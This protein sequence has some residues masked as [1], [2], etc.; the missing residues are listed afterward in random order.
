[1]GRMYE[2][3][4]VA[5]LAALM[6]VGTTGLIGY[7]Q[8]LSALSISQTI[9]PQRIFLKGSGV[10]P[11]TAKVTL[12]LEAPQRPQRLMTD[13][14][15]V[16]DRSASFEM[17]QAVGAAQRIIDLLGPN[18]RVGLVSFATE[19]TLDARL[20][21]VASAQVVRDALSKLVSEGKTALG[22]GI[23]VATDELITSGRREA[24]LI[25]ILLTDGRTNSGRDPLEEARKANERNV[26]IYAVGIGR[27]VNRDALAQI[28][29]KTGGQFFSAYNDAI[30]DQ[31]LRVTVPANEPAA[32]NIEIVE[33]LSQ[34][35]YYEEALEN[36]PSSV[37]RNSD[38]TTTLTWK[39][40]SLRVG[41]LWTIRYTVSGSEE[42]FIPLHRSPSFVRFTDFRDREIQS[43]LSLGLV[44]EVRPRPPV[45]TPAFSVTPDNPTTY[46]E[47]QFT[48]K[49]KVEKGKIVRW[50]WSLGDGATSVEQNPVHRYAA[51]GSYAIMLTV[52]SDEGV[53]ASSSSTITVFT[54][55]VAVRRTIDT[56]IPVDQTIPGQTF[57]V[58]LQI[59]VNKRLN[60]L[61]V[62]EN[63]PSGWTVSVIE[64]STAELRLEDTQWLFSEVLEQGTVKTILYEVTVP[65]QFQEDAVY[66][67]DG[68]A[69]SASPQLNLPVTGDSEIEVL[70]GFSIP[71]VVAHWD[72]S[73]QAL[74]LKGH[75]K[76]KIDLNQILRAI[77]WWR[78]GMEVPSTEDATGK[79]K[80]IDFKTMQELVAYWLTD[81][82]VF[83]PLPKE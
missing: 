29:E 24:A 43:D 31:I 58:T 68:T 22:E 17:G 47:V 36:A 82:S 80:K 59:Q 2:R 78:E 18:D 48:D 16:V 45:V 30:V 8:G 13:L 79:K 56:F 20:T 7:E 46:D 23:A 28:A 73:N 33:T 65:V 26:T 41:E 21:P 75:P 64:S 71:L 40:S 66:R 25:E 72:A 32:E 3:A 54:P 4:A 69:S 77:S 42:G 76:H 51:D 49:S 38:G 15:L 12:Q 61:G 70:N 57:R 83:D 1:M 39:R 34:G 14:I 60:G 50:L 67:I 10:N 11:E 55:N 44:L 63:V 53:E 27:F 6:L 19:G 5:I 35:L 62:D 37:I 9:E 52:T 81:T 74:D